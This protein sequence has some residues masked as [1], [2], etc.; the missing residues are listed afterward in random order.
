MKRVALV[1]LLLLSAVALGGA[2]RPE[3]AS[4]DD[5]PARAPDTVSVT[6]AGT[7]SAVPDRAEITAGVETRRATASAALAA[8]AAAME[9]V[10]GALRAAGGEALT[11]QVVS[12]SPVTD[13]AGKP[14]GFVA[15]NAVSA[16]TSLA[17]AGA[18]V[19]AAVAAGANTVWGPTLSRSD[20]DALY[21]KALAAAVDDARLRAGVLAGAAGREV[22]RVVA[23]VEQGASV[24]P[25]FAK[26]E[27]ASDAQ[28]P[29]V[30]GPQETAAT[31]SVTFE[32]R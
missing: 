8:N 7:V 26:A 19:D 22:G 25:L 11:T 4:A 1:A 10:I 21:R 24:P 2:L 5:P 15:S 28:T 30:S 23:I 14:S 32:L 16:E 17:R 27:A 13:D 6:G 3:R 9:D 18:L 29:I 12:L 31:V 20:A